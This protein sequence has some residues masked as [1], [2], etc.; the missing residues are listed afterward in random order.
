MILF[1]K[2]NLLI[3]KVDHFDDIEQSWNGD[4][5]WAVHY[6]GQVRLQK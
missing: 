3:I 5:I 1:D 4:Y 2:K 6:F